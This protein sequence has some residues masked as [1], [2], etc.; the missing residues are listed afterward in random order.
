MEGSRKET[1]KEGRERGKTG[2]Q[3]STGV[4]GSERAGRRLQGQTLP[5]GQERTKVYCKTVL[6]GSV[7]VKAILVPWEPEASQSGV[8]KACGYRKQTGLSRRLRRQIRSAD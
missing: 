7:G 5:G 6:S 3:E 2:D 4:T 8:S 1:G